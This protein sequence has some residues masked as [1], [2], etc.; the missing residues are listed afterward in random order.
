MDCRRCKL[1]LACPWRSTRKN[2]AMLHREEESSGLRPIE[3][4][5]VGH[6]LEVLLV[7]RS[8]VPQRPDPAFVVALCWWGVAS[9][10]W[11]NR[12]QGKGLPSFCPSVKSATPIRALAAAFLSDTCAILRASL[13][14]LLSDKSAIM[15]VQPMSAIISDRCA[16]FEASAASKSVSRRID[17]LNDV[18]HL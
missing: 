8:D 16:I 14:V 17:D 10:L 3:A 5:G 18:F 11:R 4:R 9:P 1:G 13:L 7:R 2:E 15:L 6:F 12:L